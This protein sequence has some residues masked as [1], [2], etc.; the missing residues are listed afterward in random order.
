[1]ALPQNPDGLTAGDRALLSASLE[2]TNKLKAQTK[3]LEKLTD[4]ISKQQ[5]EY[6]NLRKDI[7]ES[8]KK[9]FEGNGKSF[10]EIKKYSRPCSSLGRGLRVVQEIDKAIVGSASNNAATKE[11]LPAPEGATTSIMLP[12]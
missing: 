1:M 9:L 3:V 11:D 5:K 8:Q 12:R 6:G 7:Q 2:Q 4:A 10:S